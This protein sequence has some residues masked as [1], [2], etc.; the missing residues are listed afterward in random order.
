M[1]HIEAGAARDSR[2]HLVLV[3]IECI[4]QGVGQCADVLDPQFGDDIH[5]LSSA[6]HA[7]QRAGQ[8]AADEI[9]NI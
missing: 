8:R 4:F 3:H 5:V 7:V 9:W 2:G 1:D 6:H